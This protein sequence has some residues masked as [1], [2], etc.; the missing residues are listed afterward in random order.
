M[1]VEFNGSKKNRELEALDLL[2]KGKSDEY[3]GRVLQYVRDAKVDANDPTFLLMAALG[4]LDVALVDLPKAIEASGQKSSAEISK[5]ITELR[6]MFQLAA[7]QAQERIDSI[8]DAEG[9]IQQQL[10]TVSVKMT[11]TLA[12]LKKYRDESSKV[13]EFSR[14]NYQK[15][16]EE[17]YTRHQQLLSKTEKLGQQLEAERQLRMSKPWRNAVNLP[18]LMLV[19]VIV[20]PLIIGLLIGSNF[21]NKESG[22]IDRLRYQIYD[23]FKKPQEDAAKELL[24]KE[25]NKK[26]RK[27]RG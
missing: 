10:D 3:K 5:M 25:N 8:N 20:L 18:P 26:S 16:V 7:K 13:L 12:T 6:T 27:N 2:L 22:N 1:A 14:D 17:N 4:N 15:L 9:R 24:I 23:T 19:A 21:T 11:E